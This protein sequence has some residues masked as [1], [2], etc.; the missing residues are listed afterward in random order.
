MT[1]ALDHIVMAMPD[2]AA[3]C[4]SCLDAG[5]QLTPQA[6]HQADMGTTNRLIQLQDRSFIELLTVDRPAGIRPHE[7]PFFSFGQHNQDFLAN[8]QGASMLVMQ[9]TDAARDQA[10]FAANGSNYSLFAFGRDAQRPDGSVKKVG[11]RLAFT[12]SPALPGLAFFVCE[13]QY[14]ENFWQPALQTH[15]NG[16]AGI[17]RVVIETNAPHDAAQWFADMFGGAKADDGDGSL[18][19]LAADQQ[20][21]FTAGGGRQAV[22]SRIDIAAPGAACSVIKLGE[23]AVHLVA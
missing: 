8:R 17:R 6:F 12:T 13:N 1:R 9:T 23:T 21:Q 3:A 7:N 4:Q 19:R 20:V 22:I 15:P 5:F 16:A 14:P 18:V 11:F 10:H 2:L